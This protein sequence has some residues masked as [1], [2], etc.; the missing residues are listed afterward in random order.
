MNSP[1]V[2]EETEF[3][4][5][6]FENNLYLFTNL[7]NVSFGEII[8]IRIWEDLPQKKEKEKKDQ[9]QPKQHNNYNHL[10]VL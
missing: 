8:I 1:S 2:A 5:E 10:S 7:T 3:E 9:A 4:Y 6:N